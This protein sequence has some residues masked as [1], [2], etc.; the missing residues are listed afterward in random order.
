VTDSLPPALLGSPT[1]LLVALV[2]GRATFDRSL[3][4]L[5]ARRLAD[6]GIRVSF[7]PSRPRPARRKPV[8]RG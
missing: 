1:F 6:I 4:R 3:E 8:P 2:A 5:A 7:T